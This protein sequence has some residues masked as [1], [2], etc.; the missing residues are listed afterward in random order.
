M[1]SIIKNYFFNIITYIN[2]NKK[3]SKFN[4]THFT[5]VVLLTILLILLLLNMN[6]FVLMYIINVSFFF[7]NNFIDYKK[8]ILNN[9]CYLYFGKNTMNSNS[10]NSIF[11]NNHNEDENDY[12]KKIKIIFKI[13]S[14][15]IETLIVF[16]K[17]YNTIVFIIQPFIEKIHIFLI[18]LKKRIKYKLYKFIIILKPYIKGIFNFLITIIVGIIS[19]FL[20][21]NYLDIAKKFFIDFIFGSIK[22]IFFFFWNIMKDIL[23]ALFYTFPRFLKELFITL[24]FKSIKPLMYLIIILIIIYYVDY[25]DP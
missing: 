5:M 6:K 13:I 21:I 14:F 1:E 22:G 11:D 15:C 12:D 24:L 17:I 18:Y 10:T 25:Y 23:E 9:N 4:I 2:A 8:N 16:Y 20:S 19:Y 3:Y 7:Y